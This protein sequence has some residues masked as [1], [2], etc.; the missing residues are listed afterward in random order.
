MIVSPQ[1]T[2]AS[3]FLHQNV[4]VP[5]QFSGEIAASLWAWI[6]LRCALR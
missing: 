6:E 5:A 3:T 4:S 2:H 1:R